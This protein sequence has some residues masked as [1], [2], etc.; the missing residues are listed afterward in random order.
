VCVCVCLCVYVNSTLM[1]M[2]SHLLNQGMWVLR[3][4]MEIS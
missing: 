3:D 2:F 1:T 4:D